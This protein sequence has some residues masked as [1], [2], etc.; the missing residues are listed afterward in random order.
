[1]Y[2]IV[3]KTIDMHHLGGKRKRRD[4]LVERQV[5]HVCTGAADFMSL[6]RTRLYSMIFVCS[7]RYCNE[8]TL[9][10]SF[11]RSFMS[12]QWPLR[13]L[14]CALYSGLK[15]LSVIQQLP[16]IPRNRLTLFIRWFRLTSPLCLPPS[17]LETHTRYNQ[18]PLVVRHGING[19]EE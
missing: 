14:F 2:V 17:V 12:L 9:V 1:M 3:A 18:M 16:Y 11:P 13:V 6:E 8:H 7:W 5:R 4:C 19:N 15:P 10:D